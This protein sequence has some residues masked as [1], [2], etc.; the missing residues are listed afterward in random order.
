MPLTATQAP[1]NANG[2]V[3]VI[4]GD[5]Y[6]NADGRALVWTNAAWPSL[7]GATITLKVRDNTKAVLLTKTGTVVSATSARVDLTR[8]DTALATGAYLFNLVAALS[9]SADV[10]TLVDG[11]F[12]VY[13]AGG[14]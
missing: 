5:D 8:T 10:T 2:D 6:L 12:V 4:A 13:A 3:A 7:T 14:A 9:G 11:V 1:V